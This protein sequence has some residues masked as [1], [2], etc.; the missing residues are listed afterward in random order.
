MNT[1]VKFLIEIQ[2]IEYEKQLVLTLILLHL[3][4]YYNLLKINLYSSKLI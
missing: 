1:I 2:C 4:I 3:I